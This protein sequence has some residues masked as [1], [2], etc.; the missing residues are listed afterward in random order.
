MNAVKKSSP[1]PQLPNVVQAKRTAGDR[2]AGSDAARD[3]QQALKKNRASQ[4]ENSG[5]LKVGRE[6][7]DDLNRWST[8]D[9]LRGQ[10]HVCTWTDLGAPGSNADSHDDDP[11]RRLV[12]VNAAQESAVANAS[13]GLANLETCAP[14]QRDP[15]QDPDQLEPL[16]WSH[17]STDIGSQGQFELW[18]PSGQHIGVQYAVST[19]ATQL[20]LEAESKSLSRQLQSCASGIGQRMSQRCG[21]RVDVFAA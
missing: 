11:S 14:V 12:S 13:P 20:L 8:D 16:L 4:K 21:R 15:I 7:S 18:L 17:M 5:H 3:F 1:S 6:P 9:P 10:A 19:Q 2:P